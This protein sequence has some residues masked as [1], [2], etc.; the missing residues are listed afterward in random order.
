MPIY[1]L[2]SMD[3]DEMKCIILSMEIILKKSSAPMLIV[4]SDRIRNELI[5]PRIKLT[6]RI[7]VRMIL[8]F[9]CGKGSIRCSEG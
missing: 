9:A 2:D 1:F 4:D 7:I 5:N 3:H 6:K 8:E